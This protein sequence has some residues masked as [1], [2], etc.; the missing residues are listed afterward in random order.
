M[1]KGQIVRVKK[2]RSD[3]HV[4]LRFALQKVEYRLRVFQSQALR[5]FQSLAQSA[6]WV[7]LFWVKII[8]G[9]AFLEM[10]VFGWSGK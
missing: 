7:C 2:R 6:F 3:Y 4:N 10:W 1:K 9:N 8:S 5:V